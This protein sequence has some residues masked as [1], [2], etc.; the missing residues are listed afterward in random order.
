[1]AD[2]VNYNNNTVPDMGGT[3]VRNG[4]GSSSNNEKTVLVIVIVAIVLIAVGVGS[5]YLFFKGSDDDDVEVDDDDDVASVPTTRSLS[6][7]P[8]TPLPP[9][10]SIKKK[11]PVVKGKRTKTKVSKRGPPSKRTSKPERKKKKKKKT[12]VKGKKEPPSKS[13]RTSKPERKKKKK[14]TAVKGKKQ[15][16]SKSKRTSKP[17]RKK[18]KK[19]E[20]KG[21]KEPPFYNGE[22]PMI[23]RDCADPTLVWDHREGEYVASGTS[24]GFN[25]YVSSDLKAWKPIGQLLEGS[26]GLHW[27]PEI[28]QYKGAWYMTYTADQK[29]Y[30]AKSTTRKARGPYRPHSGPLLPHWSIDSSV[31]Q[32]RDGT[33]Y[34]YWNEGD[35]VKVGILN[36]TL[37]VLSKPRHCF[38]VHTHP[39]RWITETVQE[40]PHV[41]DHEGSIYIFFSGNA[42][43]AKYGIGCA[44][45]RHPYD[46]PFKKLKSNP[47]LQMNGS[48]HCSIV[49]QKS[50]TYLVAFHMHSGGEGRNMH[51]GR[52]VF[53]KGIPRLVTF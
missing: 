35:G 46:G 34:L 4:S 36:E 45:A 33:V 49:K 2:R 15:P 12:A 27:A 47:L 41:V 50:N 26:G 5:Y 37:S 6:T 30:I 20:V 48:G 7:T 21:K 19:T 28:F 40:A 1:M 52:L 18:K 44:V 3:A 22:F 24:Q 29:L 25:G 38:G 32:H 16:P 39:E 53:E 8:T 13:K 51:L 31:Y 23:I 10:I 14:K 43:G 42:T 17:E 9:S 11:A